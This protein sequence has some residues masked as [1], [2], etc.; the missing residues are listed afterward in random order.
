[1]ANIKLSDKKL[2]EDAFGMNGGYVLDF[3][4][5]SFA[6]FFSTIGVD[7]TDEQYLKNGTSKANRLRAFWEIANEELVAQSIIEMA[8][9][10]INKNLSILTRTSVLPAAKQIMDARR[11]QMERVKD[12]ANRLKTMAK[13][14]QQP[15]NRPQL[16]NCLQLSIRPEIFDHIKPYLQNEDYFHAVEEAYKLVRY[17]LRDVTG[18]ER[19]SEAFNMNAENT[20]YWQR[21][22]GKAPVK[23]TPEYD[24]CRG[25]GYLHL[26]VQFLRNEKAHKPADELDINLAMHYIVLASL[27]YELISRGVQE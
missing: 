20:K 21:L 24:F 9:L 25:V 5:K 12:V 23:D 16:D 14:I 22:F 2:L 10:V 1:M 27:A 17:K 4:D 8:D 15:R 7:I 13:V 26:G 19:A 3:S 6:E 18:C 11:V